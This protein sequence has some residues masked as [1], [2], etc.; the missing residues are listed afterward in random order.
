LLVGHRHSIVARWRSTRISP[1]KK[2]KKPLDKQPNLCYIIPMKKNK[3]QQVNDEFN[4][5][6][7]D[8]VFMPM[9]KFAVTLM[10][11]AIVLDYGSQMIEAIDTLTN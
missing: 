8:Q 5:M 2:L 3:I 6:F 1:W 9:V 10:F 7:A 11:V 4:K